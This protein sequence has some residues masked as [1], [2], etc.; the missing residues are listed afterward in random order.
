MHVAT[1]RQAKDLPGQGDFRK[2]IPLELTPDDLARLRSLQPGHGSMRATL[3]AGLEA[4]AR[5]EQAEA[6]VAELAAARDAAQARVGKLE[7]EA[8]AAK[9][10]SAKED[11][12]AKRASR[13]TKDGADRAAERART[14][15]AHAAQRERD[16]ADAQS[17]YDAAYQTLLELDETRVDE[18]RCPR[19]GEF[20]A[21]AEWGYQESEEGGQLI[22]HQPCGFHQKGLLDATTIM[23][24]RH[25]G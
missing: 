13:A 5:L 2:R 20:A 15:E 14:L 16:L 12:T 22:F 11:A 4:L 7:A 17:A 9:A 3:L 24:Y 25:A 6:E 8:A 1:P 19:C 10:A 23:G 21:S 18:L